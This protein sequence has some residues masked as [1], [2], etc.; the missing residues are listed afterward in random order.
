MVSLPLMGLK[1]A[2]CVSGEKD[3]KE[4]GRRAHCS[5]S[6]F[7]Y[8]FAVADNYNKFLQQFLQVTQ[9]KC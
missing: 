8:G 3:K 5:A 9:L 4:Y 2:M 1:I 6:Q 7:S